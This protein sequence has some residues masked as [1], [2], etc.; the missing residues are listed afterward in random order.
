[1]QELEVEKILIL[2]PAIAMFFC[3]FSVI[4]LL[5]MSRYRAIHNREVSIKYYEKYTD[6][7]QTDR[8]HIL[9]RHVQNHFEV[10]PLFY[11]GII[12]LFITDTVTLL[13][14]I[15][16]WGFVLLRCIHSTIHLGRNN[17]SQRF[18]CFGLSLISLFLLWAS[19]LVQM[20]S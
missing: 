1:M 11:I 12:L 13:A 16:A 19:L 10:P 7:Q 20:L 9:N 4:G 2:Y 5:G 6:G 18:F 8:L 15:S 3:T 14:L 17:V